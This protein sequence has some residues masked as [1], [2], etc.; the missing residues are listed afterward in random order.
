MRGLVSTLALQQ[1]NA[2]AAYRERKESEANDRDDDAGQQGWPET[3][4]RKQR[5]KRE[6]HR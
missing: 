2:E 3:E 6:K 1:L 4:A 5:R